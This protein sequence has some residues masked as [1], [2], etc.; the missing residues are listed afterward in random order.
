[1]SNTRLLIG[2]FLIILGLSA[3]FDINIWP[4]IGP[5]FLIFLGLRLM[6]KSGSWGRKDVSEIKQDQVEELAIFSAID[7][8]ISSKNFEGGKITAIFGGGDIDLRDAD[9][10]SDKIDLE[11]ISVFGGVK[12]VVPRNWNV[13]SEGAAVIG[14]FDN[15]TNVEGKALKTLRIKGAAVFGG[16]EIVN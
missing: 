2:F 3:L 14:G 5:L 12:L 7:R 16:V 6:S 8:K 10:K 15:R 11:I 4:L 1:M 13:Q 9:S